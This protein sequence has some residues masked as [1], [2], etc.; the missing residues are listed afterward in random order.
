M[1]LCTLTLDKSSAN[2]HS[3]TDLIYKENDRDGSWLT[4]AAVLPKGDQRNFLGQV[5]L[6]PPQVAYR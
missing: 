3:R 6:V 1:P 2:G 4:L 5:K